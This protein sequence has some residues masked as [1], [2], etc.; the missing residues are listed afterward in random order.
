MM[1]DLRVR[2]IGRGLGN[3]EKVDGRGEERKRK[4]EGCGRRAQIKRRSEG[5]KMTML[6]VLGDRLTK[7]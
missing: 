2:G 4:E 1:R 3:G 7:R 5:G 6:S